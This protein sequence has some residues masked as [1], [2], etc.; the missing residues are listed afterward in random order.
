VERHEFS[1]SASGYAPVRLQL[2]APV[3]NPGSFLRRP[4]LPKRAGVG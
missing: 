2:F 4:V 3:S 1:F